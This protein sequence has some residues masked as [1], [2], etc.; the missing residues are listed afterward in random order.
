[1]GDSAASSRRR[2]DQT[3]R[4]APKKSPEEL[5]PSMGGGS[6]I[7]GGE[8]DKGKDE[9]EELRVKLSTER[10]NIKLTTAPITT[11]S[12]FTISAMEYLI[13][14]LRSVAL[15]IFTWLIAL[16]LVAGYFYL[17]LVYAPE[18]FEA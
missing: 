12:L 2:G 6:W 5:R 9:V 3:P 10:Q 18:L 11:V 16:P 8:K 4:T 1:M 17:K 7:N 13:Y 15:S 14:G